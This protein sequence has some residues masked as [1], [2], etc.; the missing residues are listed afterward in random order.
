ME[1][2]ILKRTLMEMNLKKKDNF[3]EILE[4]PHIYLM[5]I[6]TDGILRDTFT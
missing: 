5:E 2:S 4:I 6:R 1:M 3:L